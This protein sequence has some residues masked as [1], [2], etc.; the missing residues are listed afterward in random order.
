LLLETLSGQRTVTAAS[1]MLGISRRRF[2]T[3]RTEFLHS[4]LDML[5]PRPAGRPSQKPI[6]NDYMA[7]LEAEVH[8]LQIDLRAA[9]VREEIALA[10][11]HLLLRHRRGKKA[12][13]QKHDRSKTL[14]VPKPVM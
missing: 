5:A 9:Q 11:P 7:R 10:M 4:A 12:K 14:P 8:T 6:S 13:L 1:Q 2:H 3:L